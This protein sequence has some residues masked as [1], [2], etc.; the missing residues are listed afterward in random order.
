VTRSVSI[1][2]ADAEFRREQALATMVDA[3]CIFFSRPGEVVSEVFRRA[4]RIYEKF[5]QPHEWTLDYQGSVIGYSPREIMLRPECGLVLE[6]DMALAWSPSIGAAR[7]EDTVVVDSRGYEVMTGMQ[8]W[9][10]IEVAVKGYVI[11]RPG[12]L[13]R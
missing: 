9:P 1:G 3:T 4:K 11:P 12:I 5:G 2:K 6:S 8:N 7:T 10:A 13:E